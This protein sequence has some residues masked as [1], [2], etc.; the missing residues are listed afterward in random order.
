[1]NELIKLSAASILLKLA[2]G[3]N[4]LELLGRQ[5][6]IELKRRQMQAMQQQM[7]AMTQPNRPDMMGARFPW[8]PVSKNLANPQPAQQADQKL[9]QQRF[10]R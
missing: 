9:K 8:I 7:Q 1:M 6:L 3:G 10:Y 5:Y 2:A 4:M